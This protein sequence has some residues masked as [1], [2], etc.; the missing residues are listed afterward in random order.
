MNLI[1]L[2]ISIVP[3]NRFQNTTF[4]SA[5]G[6]QQ[7]KDPNFQVHKVA[8][9]HT[10][11]WNC[12]RLSDCIGFMST[13]NVISRVMISSDNEQWMEYSSDE[14]YLAPFVCCQGFLL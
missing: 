12:N 5:D 11:I 6:S 14:P 13:G 2:R 10:C 3:V 7:I 4:P 1:S 9:R 8:R